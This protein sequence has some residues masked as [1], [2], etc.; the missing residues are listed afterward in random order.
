MSVRSNSM[1]ALVKGASLLC[2]LPPSDGA[3]QDS[4]QQSPGV[5]I[6]TIQAPRLARGALGSHVPAP[7]E[8]FSWF[9]T[10]DAERRSIRERA[11]WRRVTARKGN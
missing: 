2:K 11:C 9:D 7:P 3:L 10:Y 6:H 4:R 8:L 5:T 1:L